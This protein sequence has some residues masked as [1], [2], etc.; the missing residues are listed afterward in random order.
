MARR[1]RRHDDPRSE[2]G[3]TDEKGEV[4]A[5]VSFN[6][7]YNR[8]GRTRTFSWSAF[9][10]ILLVMFRILSSMTSAIADMIPSACARL[11]PSRSN[12]CTK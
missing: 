4:N 10:T 12:R 3:R 6:G 9:V 7:R 11:S 8:S 5:S 1:P 2:E